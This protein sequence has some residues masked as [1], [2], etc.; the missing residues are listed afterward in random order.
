MVTAALIALQC[1]YRFGIFLHSPTSIPNLVSLAEIGRYDLT[2]F[3]PMLH[4][5]TLAEKILIPAFVFFFFRTPNKT[6]LNGFRQPRQT[7]NRPS[8]RCASEYFVKV[9]PVQGQPL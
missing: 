3:M 9:G 5:Q 7:Q 4:C 1:V 2:S 6:P 8:S